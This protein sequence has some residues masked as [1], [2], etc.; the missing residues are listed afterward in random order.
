MPVRFNSPRL[1]LRAYGVPKFLRRRTVLSCR[2]L[3]GGDVDERARRAPRLS[4]RAPRLNGTVG[5]CRA[6][7]WYEATR[8]S[9]TRRFNT[10]PL[11]PFAPA[12]ET[13]RRE[14]W[15]VVD[16]CRPRLDVEC[17]IRYFYQ[18][19]KTYQ[20][21]RR[22]DGVRARISPRTTC[23]CSKRHAADDTLISE[24]NQQLAT[25]PFEVGSRRDY[26][27]NHAHVHRPQFSLAR[28][29]R[30]GLLRGL[31]HAMM[32]TADRRKHRPTSATGGP[33]VSANNVFSNCGL[34]APSHCADNC[35]VRPTERPSLANLSFPPATRRQLIA[36]SGRLGHSSAHYSPPNLYATKPI[37]AAL[38]SDRLFLH[39]VPP[40][41]SL[42]QPDLEPAKPFPRAERY[43]LASALQ[44]AIRRG[45]ICTAL[46][47]G[48][49]LLCSTARVLGL[50]LSVIALKI[51]ASRYECCV[52][53]G[54]A[55]SQRHASSTA[56]M[57]KPSTLRSCVHVRR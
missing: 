13:A 10:R 15:R 44:K 16:H 7:G 47:S 17:R 29:W 36:R 28:H 1:V 3:T 39:L 22:L 18:P 19:L 49:Q 45:D 20:V 4:Q 41:L 56:E 38:P 55:H 42:P 31:R 40:R 54:I 14:R 30:C 8:W 52:L 43:V 25:S 24:S 53:V 2:G 32:R 27:E 51:S 37:R 57:P 35:F 9:W 6:I 26:G 48:H 23:I 34:D 5:I 46:R 21:Y 50:R 11:R 33:A 12:H